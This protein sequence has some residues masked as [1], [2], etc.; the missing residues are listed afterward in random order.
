MAVTVEG[1]SLNWFFHFD[2]SEQGA[3][4]IA[5]T[6][7]EGRIAETEFTQWVQASLATIKQR[8]DD[9][10]RLVVD[11]NR[12][13]IR[14]HLSY[15][16]STS[17]C[18]YEDPSA[19]SLFGES[20]VKVFRDD[21]HPP[22][23]LWGIH[24]REMGFWKEWQ[25]K[26]SATFSIKGRPGFRSIVQ[27]NLRIL[28]TRPLG[29]DL[30]RRISAGGRRIIIRNGMESLCHSEGASIDLR[31]RRCW[32]WTTLPSGTKDSTYQFLYI[33]LAHE[34]IH[35]L[36]FF[37][38]TFVGHC[39]PT[40]DWSFS[41]LEE[42]R[43]ITGFGKEGEYDRLCE[44]GFRSQFGLPLRANHEGNPLPL[45][46]NPIPLGSKIM[47]DFQAELLIG[48]IEG[49]A[50][51]KIDPKA[52][53]ELEE[54]LEKEIRD[55]LEAHQ[56]QKFSSL[57]YCGMPFLNHI[58]LAALELNS[59]NLVQLMLRHEGEKDYR[60]ALKI[61]KKKKELSLFQ[62][63]Y[64]FRC[65]N[66][67][68]S[69]LLEEF[70]KLNA[71]IAWNRLTCRGGD[72]LLL[73]E[74]IDSWLECQADVA[75]LEFL[76]S[77]GV[78]VEDFLKKMPLNYVKNGK[79]CNSVILWA[80]RE[81]I[82]HV[83]EQGNTAL[84]QLIKVYDADEAIRWKYFQRLIDRDADLNFEN[85]DGES[86]L[87]SALFR[88]NAILKCKSEP[89][90]FLSSA[91]R[92]LAQKTSNALDSRGDFALF[93]VLRKKLFHAAHF[94]LALLPTP[95]SFVN[96]RGET[97]LHALAQGFILERLIEQGIIKLEILLNIIKGLIARGVDYEVKDHTGKVFLDY[98]HDPEIKKAI[99]ACLPLYH[100]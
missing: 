31:L 29:R 51:A 74:G 52:Q 79:N 6:I 57:E 60:G 82:N 17:R 77:V 22:L 39:P 84:H 48:L 44:N 18:P 4:D 32:V 10:T 92:V 41:T 54:G 73:E 26:M 83:D 67:N 30:I 81:N 91:I 20:D 24:K 11:R 19:K 2:L 50:Q 55:F 8:R 53:N 66:K 34:L 13:R 56:K 42:Q 9:A 36:H 33:S 90:M 93:S 69:F 78:S 37:D 14:S 86:P 7:S 96:P 28:L 87:I 16:K 15:L 65:I 100:E 1:F 38:K 76:L 58:L 25:D 99:L 72:D 68:L 27:D 46:M 70:I 5:E 89:G 80:L 98:F 59:L 61:D 49:I 47:P 71:D 85:N 63:A 62:E 43:T 12:H 95:L 94:L 75:I 3:K 23:P 88:Y 35:S 97:A 64:F 45:T 21:Y 40:L